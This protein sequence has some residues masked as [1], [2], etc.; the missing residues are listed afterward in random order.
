M[1]MTCF[2]GKGTAMRRDEELKRELARA[3]IP[4]RVTDAALEI[5]AVLQR[6][7]RRIVTRELGQR[8][9][10]D[11]GL[12]LDLAQLDVLVAV[13]A[14]ANEF[15]DEAGSETMVATV[16]A[17]LGIDPSRASRISAD[18]IRKGYARRAA[19]QQDARRT[20]IEPTERGRAA[21]EA[22]RGYKFLVMGEFLKG[23]T[24][25]EIATFLPLLERFSAWSEQQ[26]EQDPT[27]IAA[28]IAELRARLAEVEAET[29]A[30]P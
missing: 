20:V 17:R 28:E 9:L 7:R 21:V 6:W 18:L 14:P 22:V 26:G 3:G 19:S 10:A 1:S 11:L 15:G 27:A 24:A 25:E 2:S 12:D 29:A 5:D 13:V 8:A 23:W 4:E 30:H 16:A